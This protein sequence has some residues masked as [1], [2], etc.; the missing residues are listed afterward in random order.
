MNEGELHE[1]LEKVELYL[2][3]E[4][5]DIAFDEFAGVGIVEMA[6]GYPW[7]VHVIGQSALLMADKEGRSQILDGDVHRVVSSLAK[8]QFAQ[9]FGDIY[10]NI[11]RNSLQREM[12]LR[13]FASW[14]APDIPTSEVY[15]VLKGKLKVTNPSIYSTQLKGKTYGQVIHDKLGSRT[16][17]RFDNEM[18]KVYVRLVPSVYVDVDE[19]VRAATREVWYSE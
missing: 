5:I 13:V 8:N 7:F 17:V 19:R 11:V 14:R 6:A 2:H 3:E 15:K 4:G 18:F 1:I 12:V 9:Q 10:Q 16:W